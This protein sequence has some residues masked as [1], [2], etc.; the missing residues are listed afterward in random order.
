MKEYFYVVG[1][2]TITFLSLLECHV[3]CLDGLDLA[4]VE[5]AVGYNVPF[6]RIT[7]RIVED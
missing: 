1:P 3:I 7:S 5:E 6:M 2:R 4:F